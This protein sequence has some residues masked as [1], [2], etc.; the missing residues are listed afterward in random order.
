MLP[1][2]EVG[3]GATAE[4]ET[5]IAWAFQLFVGDVL[6]DDECPSACDDTISYDHTLI[7]CHPSVFVTRDQSSPESPH[8]WAGRS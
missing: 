3:Q 8:R 6:S 7:I 5:W 4:H 2:F 1:E